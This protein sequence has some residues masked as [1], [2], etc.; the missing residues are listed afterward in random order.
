MPHLLF[1]R[2][3]M[4]IGSTGLSSVSKGVFLLDSMVEYLALMELSKSGFL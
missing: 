4:L 2:N 1:C 3:L